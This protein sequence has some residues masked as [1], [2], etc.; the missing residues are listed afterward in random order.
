MKFNI[1]S[2][3][4]HY[5][6]ALKSY[7]E[8]HYQNALQIVFNESDTLNY[9]VISEEAIYDQGLTF[10]TTNKIMTKEIKKY[11]SAKAF[12]NFLKTIRMEDFTQDLPFRTFGFI[13]A[14]SRAGSTT[15]GLNLS[16]ALSNRG[17]TLFLS[18]EMA[19]ST[20]F[21]MDKR[22]GISLSDISF[23]LKNDRG[24]LVN[25]LK[26]WT[27]DSFYWFDPV[28][29]DEDLNFFNAC[30]IKDLIGIAKD[31]EFSNLVID[32]GNQRDWMKSKIIEEE[33]I[34]LE[35]SYNHFYRIGHLIHGKNICVNKKRQDIY[36]NESYISTAQSH[37]NVD[38]DY[39]LEEER[40]WRSK[41]IQSVMLKHLNMT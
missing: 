38:F 30:H 21:Y 7:Y 14:L 37:F 3:D 13:N 34:V 6:D 40:Q 28:E 5:I 23:Y 12:F 1:I 19:S 36:L 39:G 16:E 17:R 26:D 25:K 20:M 8:T 35:Y 2:K 22:S 32:F 29:H 10:S 33:I 18:L 15:L 31:A 11:Q 24:L 27:M 4:I 41:A 9:V